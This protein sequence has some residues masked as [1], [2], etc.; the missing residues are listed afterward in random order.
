MCLINFFSVLEEE[1]PF[2]MRDAQN[3]LIEF[4]VD[5]NV[6]GKMHKILDKD[7]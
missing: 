1:L 7:H 2:V 5:H 6:I 3:R 4:G